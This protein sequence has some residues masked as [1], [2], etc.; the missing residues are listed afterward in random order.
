MFDWIVENWWAA[1][2]FAPAF[3]GLFRLV[4]KK[5]V[6][7]EDSTDYSKLVKLKKEYPSCYSYDIIEEEGKYVILDK[8]SSLNY[9]VVGSSTI[10]CAK[11]HK[12][13]TEN[14]FETK[15]EAYKVVYLILQYKNDISKV[16]P[17]ASAKNA[18]T[19]GRNI[20]NR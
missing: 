1:A 7:K 2:L 15:A 20:G 8:Y 9:G 5:I 18:S 16:G 10:S 17:K 3:T 12:G 13:D 19:E 6:A 11:D 14:V 4:C